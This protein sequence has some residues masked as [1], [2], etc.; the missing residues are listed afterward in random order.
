MKVEMDWL[1]LPPPL[2]PA[3]ALLSSLSSQRLETMGWD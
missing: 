2:L 1:D 3:R